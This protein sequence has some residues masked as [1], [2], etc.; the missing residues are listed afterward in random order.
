MMTNLAHDLRTTLLPQY[1]TILTSVTSLL[2]RTLVSDTLTALLATLS[3]LFRYIVIPASQLLR[4]TWVTLRK[5]LIDSTTT[6]KG[7][8]GEE[9]RRMLAEVWGVLLRRLKAS[10]REEA[11]TL[12]MDGLE[13]CEEGVAWVL[14][15]AIKV[16]GSFI[17]PLCIILRNWK[18]APSHS[19][20][21][22][23]MAILGQVLNRYL[24]ATDSTKLQQ[25]LSRLLTALMHHCSS[26][27]GFAPI[28]DCLIIKS[29]DEA[30]TNVSDQAERTIRMWRVL[31]IVCA[32]RK[33]KRLSCKFFSSDLEV[34]IGLS[35][36]LLQQNNFTR[37]YPKSPNRVVHLFRKWD[38]P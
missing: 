13:D 17:Y 26:A 36:C 28:S 35:M 3:S 30:L 33:G 9:L 4:P 1:P 25:L 8:A 10:Q 34:F 6:Q 23:S 27:T 21:P 11:V 15:Y 38:P 19:L 32:V 12:L 5:C 29:R 20:H 37:Y 7:V 14:I 16:C 18:Q 24:E 22:C 2:K 31:T